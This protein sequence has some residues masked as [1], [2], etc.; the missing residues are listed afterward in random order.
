MYA[1][2]N[3]CEN[4]T[5]PWLFENLQ[6][7]IMKLEELEIPRT[8]QEMQQTFET[9]YLT[10]YIQMIRMSNNNLNSYVQTFIDLL[11]EMARSRPTTPNVIRAAMGVVALH[12][13]GYKNF[14]QLTIIFDR[15]LPQIDVEYVKFMSWCAG[16]LIHHPK[17]DQ[18]RYVV[19]L[20]DRL[21]GWSR[22]KGRRA[23]PLA[24]TYLL[25]ALATNAG[26]SVIGFLPTLK[27][28]MWLL[29]SHQS[30]QVLRATADAISM[31]T[32][33]IIRYRR[34]ELNS[35]LHF[36]SQLCLKLLHFGAPIREYAALILYEQ[37][38]KSSPDYFLP[39]MMDLYYSIIDA[40]ADEPMLVI[41]S[42]FCTLCALSLVDSK[43]FVDKIADDLFSQVE[44]VI[45]EFPKEVVDAISLLCKTIP[46]FIE[47]K[48]DILK[49]YVNELVSESDSA[50]SLLTALIN[51]FGAKALPIEEKIINELLKT[52]INP[53]YYQFF[54]ALANVQGFYENTPKLLCE[55][56]KTELHRPGSQIIDILELI[57]QLPTNSLYDNKGLLDEVALLNRSESGLIRSAI[58]KAIFN[59][60]IADPN[61]STMD[62]IML[63]IQNAINE[64][65]S[66]VRRSTLKV[67]HQNCCELLASPEILQHFQIF[68]NDD[69]V[70]VKKIT[71]QIFASIAQLNP[72]PVSAYTRFAILDA[73]FIIRHTPSIREVARYVG[74]LPY[75]VKAATPTIKAYSGGFI[76][77]SL[78]M[79]TQPTPKFVNFME[80]D[81]FN[82]ILI[83]VIDSL[84]L[85]APIDSKQVAYYGDIIIPLICDILL[86]NE[87]R[88]LSL[89]ILNLIHVLLSAPSANK[90]YREKA[91]LIFSACSKFLAKTHSRK[92]RIATLKSL[93]AIGVLEVHQ[94]A[95]PTNCESP[96][97]IEDSL[98][99]QFFHP[100]RD[101][102]NSS[103][104]ESL[105][106]KGDNS[107]SQYY[108]LI[109]SSSLLEILKDDSMHEYYEDVVNALVQ[110]LKMPRMF[111]LGY[112]DTFVS[113]LLELMENSDDEHIKIFM[114]Y[115]SQLI[116]TSSHNTSPFLK[117]SLSLIHKRFCP[118][119]AS[120]FLDVILAFLNSMRDGYSPY[121]SDT[122]CLLMSCLDDFK[123]N[124]E[125][126]SIQC[127]SALEILGIYAIELLYLIV[128]SVS[129]AILCEQTLIKVRI[130]GLET[131]MSLSK[132]VDMYPYLGSIIRAVSFSIYH[133]DMKTRNVA[134][135][136]LYTLIKAQ[137]FNFIKCASPLL[138][139]LK[140]EKMETDYLISLIQKCKIESESMSV[141]KFKPIRTS[142]YKSQRR[143]STVFLPL[144]QIHPFSEEAIIVRIRT[145]NV[146]RHTD[147]WMRSLVLAVISNSPSDPIRACSSLVSSYYPL[148]LKLSNSAFLS[149]WTFISEQG[150]QTIIETFKQ[151]LLAPENY[152]GVMRELYGLLV[153][154]DKI[155]R[156]FD[157][158]ILKP[159][160]I[161][162]ACMRYGGA[163]LALHTQQSIFYENPENINSIGHLI[164]I[165]V[166]TGDMQNALGVWRR[167]QLKNSTLNKI[168]VL[169]RLKMWDQVLPNFKEKFNRT[170]D[171][172]SFYGMSKAMASLAMWP[173]LLE[174]YSTFQSLKSHQKRDVSIYFS[175]AALHSGRWDILEET[176]K[177]APDD[178]TR[179]CAMKALNAVYKR[180]LEAVD[181]NIFYGFSLLASRPITFWIENQ[182]IHPKTIKIAQ[183]LIEIGEMK[184]WITGEADT[185][186][187]DMV[188]NNR[189]ETAPRDFNI[190]FHLIVNRERI[191][192]NIREDIL[193]KFFLLKSSSI[194]SKIHIN[195]FDLLFPDFNYQTAPEHQKI[196]YVIAHWNAGERQRAI[197]EME[198]LT[199][200]VS[201]ELKRKCHFLYASWLLE[202]D[203]DLQ[204]LQKAYQQL[205][206]V[207][208]DNNYSNI[209]FA[210]NHSAFISNSE[211]NQ[212]RFQKLTV[213]LKSPSV[214][215]KIQ[216][217]KENNGNLIFPSQVI[218]EFSTDQSNIEL[219]RM[220]SDVNYS[221]ISLDQ[222][223]DKEYI[224]NALNALIKSSNISPSFPDVV[225]LLNIFF[226]HANDENIFNDTA[227]FI[228]QLPPK[229]LIQASPQ[230]LIQL[231]HSTDNVAFFV[232][233]IVLK[234]LEEH[235][236]SLLFPVVVMKKSANRARSIA[237]KKILSA[238][239]MKKPNVYQETQL[240]RKS[241]LMA[242]VTWNEKILQYI[243]DAYEHFQSKHFDRVYANL[244]AIINISK[245]PKCEMHK[246]FLQQF[247][248]NIK[249][250][251]QLLKIF[252][253]KV[254]ST[255]T[256]ILNWCQQM[257]Q[258]I[259]EE[260]KRIRLIQ[261][262]SISQTLS[263]KTGFE[264]AVLGTYKPYQKINHIQYFVGQ[265]SVYLSKQQPKDVICKG[266]DGNFYRYLLK[267]H[268]DL[269]LD[270]RIMQFFRLINSFIIKSSA[271]QQNQI[272]TMSVI[273]LSLQHGLVQWVPGTETL[274][275]IVEQQRKLHNRDPM[276]EYNLTEFYTESSYDYLLPVQKLHVIKRIFNEVPDTDISDFFWLKASNA[277]M[278]L[279]QTNNFAISTGMTS[280][281]GYIIG[282]G[283]RHPSNLLIDRFTGNVIHIDF[284]DC[285]E[286]AAKRSLLPE[287]V[288]FRLTRMMVRAMGPAATEG[289]FRVSFKNMSQLLRDNKR[290]LVMVLS[291]FVHEPLV[292][293]DISADELAISSGTTPKLTMCDLEAGKSFH[294]LEEA[295]IQSSVEMRKRVIQKLTGNDFDEAE[296]LSVEDQATLLIKTATD[297]YVLSKMY[298]GWCP[299][300]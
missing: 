184:K 241:L 224:N 138:I 53:P 202:G 125:T 90:Q 8:C 242:A 84:A 216:R 149:C 183:E 191:I 7:Y 85:L 182:K 262:S 245:K 39:K 235:Y 54:V 22:A 145:P 148:A 116:N 81:A 128:P 287:V 61:I 41:G 124:D 147:Q 208:I 50:F 232:H 223:N 231:S 160:E 167:C 275:V 51:Q 110:V 297:P 146:G 209:N 115:F 258:L 49:S 197:N 75:L 261:L 55:R 294:P 79:L 283:D 36:F 96:E 20:F 265:L 94:K 175:E 286:R 222:Q 38:I 299:F 80:E 155:E 238:F 217:A 34:S 192:K 194:G 162:Q 10:F 28:V 280:I 214:L 254:K 230:I 29:V 165:F 298:S 172:S 267:G 114:P 104:D 180:D 226:D 284:G 260:V 173:Q 157:K 99:R 1:T 153:F 228:R 199:N 58:P 279:K 239:E 57:S 282:L 23:R 113:R 151:L 227:P 253:P 204:T 31:F 252:D 259:G 129:H 133:H 139:S 48:I 12:R 244:V 103:L 270:E 135:E 98:A 24:A 185:E 292:D 281:V 77:I 119:L 59:L 117:R 72:L 236:H 195:A 158:Q 247:G 6:T 52:N 40:I 264:I 101:A 178:S 66:Y 106:L 97:N 27:S 213:D 263:E 221:L 150:K 196:C 188:W 95:P 219:L 4:V 257:Q 5:F 9:Y 141:H 32:R 203:D 234:L 56:I 93:G 62:T 246:Y 69:S 123:V 83:G 142:E 18:N 215:E 86:V 266:E 17:I 177:H 3:I 249:N 134:Y 198:A 187:I 256:Q 37:L 2:Y 269:R 243:N 118:Y 268:E 190:W 137:G 73:F 112:F 288:P 274:R 108:T 300:W 168:D 154:M 127:L 63:L 200:E 76:D 179:V 174:N 272:K 171:F 87:N 82:T 126:V 225:Q 250:L 71:F 131:L 211:K 176:L 70:S 277:E 140:E 74:T 248:Q 240:I 251:E 273:P 159:E 19:H 276:E 169:T 189:L 60:G 255:M 15:L 206:F 290:V 92:A 109:V 67:L 120:Q 186:A 105:L 163:A 132:N 229:L 42:S 46:D 78:S 295:G 68:L 45:F 181:E 30:T 296:K 285:F 14:Y 289:S 11:T 44:I 65:S 100:S 193:I 233:E 218:T 21:V 152:E 88:L 47:D 122:I 237:A 156:P 170:R 278:W 205:S 102:E 293:P 291:T 91:P 207:T 220:W 121:A 35:Y 161:V 201:G 166:Q 111:L 107:I 136:L 212:T 16:R 64:H 210:N 43:L 13:F 25:T 143:P 164:D 271:F 130:T 33:A 89:S 26:S 144:E